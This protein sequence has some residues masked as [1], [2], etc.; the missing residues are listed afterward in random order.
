MCVLLLGGAIA[1]CRAAADPALPIRPAIA[2]TDV[3]RGRPTVV[4]YS[5]AVGALSAPLP[6]DVRAFVHFLAN[7]RI[8]FTDDHVPEQPPSE[9][10]A[11]RT[12][13]YARTRFVPAPEGVAELEVRMGLY[14]PAAD[15]RVALQGDH[16]RTHEY[17]V[18]RVAVRAPAAALPVVYR[19][20]WYIPGEGTVS[21]WTAREARVT[22]RNPHDGAIVYLEAETNGAAFATPPTLTLQAGEYA[23]TLPVPGSDLFL[24]AVRFPA[25]ALGGGRSSDMRLVMSASFVPRASGVG[26][27]QREL[28]LLVH[29]LSVAPAREGVPEGFAVTEAVHLP[30]PARHSP[31]DRNDSG[32]P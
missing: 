21:S 30:P 2:S 11:G 9:W 7:G 28:G 8:V 23:A 6:K 14:R 29:R 19:E 12:Y 22:F 24:A 25:E 5:W 4:R 13:E 1:G 27:D 31:A 16:A 10:Q 18:G 20:G 17:S 32:G 3:L 26:V 15:T